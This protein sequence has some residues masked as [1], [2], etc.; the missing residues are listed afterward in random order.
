MNPP[1]P[2][3]D[4]HCFDDDTGKDVWSHSEAQLLAYRA[5]VIEMCANQVESWNTAITD[6]ISQDLR[7]IK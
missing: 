4:T 3:P 2:K 1:L 6:R 5:E 7:N